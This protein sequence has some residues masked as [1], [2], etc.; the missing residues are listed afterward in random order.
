MAQIFHQFTH[1]SIR[2]QIP[3]KCIKKADSPKGA[4][5]REAVFFSLQSEAFWRVSGKRIVK[6]DP[7][8]HMLSTKTSAP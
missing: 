4:D 1:F 7:S 8:C 6:V 5:L 3:K 2:N